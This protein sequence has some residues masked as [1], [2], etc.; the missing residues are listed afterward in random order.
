MVTRL[1]HLSLENNNLGADGAKALSNVLINLTYIRSFN[2]GTKTKIII[3]NNQIKYKGAEEIA[4]SIEKLNLINSI[5]IC[6]IS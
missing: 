6:N 2:I 4:K 1:I 5:N 3:G